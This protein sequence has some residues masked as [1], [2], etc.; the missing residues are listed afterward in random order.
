[1][2]IQQFCNEWLNAWSGNQPERLLAYYSE[3]TF[4]YDP[5]FPNGLK[6]KTELK[7]YFTKLLAA[8][9]QWKW[10]AVEVFSTAKGFTLKWKA[11]VPVKNLTISFYGLDIV[12]LEGNKISRNEVYFDRYEWLKL[13]GK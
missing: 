10:E 8:N 7:N 2:N 1:M 11:T 5:A 9:P 3:N 12:E 6:G 4:Y 13:L